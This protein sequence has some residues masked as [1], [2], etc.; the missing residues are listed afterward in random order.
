MFTLISRTIICNMEHSI[1][2]GCLSQVLA[3]PS[4]RFSDH[5]APLNFLKVT[6]S[7]FVLRFLVDY[8]I[9][10]ILQPISLN[11]VISK[12]VL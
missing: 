3:D 10:K 2:P 7:S 9:V 5:V 12:S 11:V 6:K 4:V 1:Q 8:K